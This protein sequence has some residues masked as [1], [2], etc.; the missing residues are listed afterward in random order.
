MCVNYFPRH[1]KACNSCLLRVE[2]TEVVACVCFCSF[3]NTNSSYVKFGFARMKLGQ[4]TNRPL[5]TFLSWYRPA[6][7]GLSWYPHIWCAGHCTSPIRMAIVLI[8]TPRIHLTHIQDPISPFPL[9]Y[10]HL[11]AFHHHPNVSVYVR[12][13]ACVCACKWLYLCICAFVHLCA[14]NLC[15]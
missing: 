6:K 1:S 9:L 13:C 15:A 11:R 8:C 10:V 12:M 3:Q 4:L 14:L 7:I 2:F 5:S